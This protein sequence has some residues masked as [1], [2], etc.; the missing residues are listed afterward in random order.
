MPEKPKIQQVSVKALF[1]KDGKILIVK[2]TGKKILPSGQEGQE[3]ELPGGRIDFGEMPRETL[4]REIKE[5]LGISDFEIGN[6]INSS[7][8]TSNKEEAS[9][10][11]IVL[12][13]KCELKDNKISLSDEHEEMDWISADEIDKHLLRE[14]YKDALIEYFSK[15]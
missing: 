4:R 1:E 2:D 13:F 8:F 5:E 3:W 7:T 14:I 9:Y 10:Q 12:I 15:G 11:F 6:I